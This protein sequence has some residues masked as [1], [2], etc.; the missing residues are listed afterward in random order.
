[1]FTSSGSEDPHHNSGYEEGPTSTSTTDNNSTASNSFLLD[2]SARR[3][4]RLITAALANIEEN[5]ELMV[6]FKWRDSVGH[7][8]AFILAAANL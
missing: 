1:M 4:W 7:L 3:D 8:R 6:N 5:D 2:R